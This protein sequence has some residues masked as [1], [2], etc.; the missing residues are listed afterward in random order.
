MAGL[1]QAWPL[2]EEF[3]FPAGEAAIVDELVAH[4]A[5]R[6]SAPEQREV[7]VQPLPADTAGPGLD[8]QQQG[9]PLTAERANAHGR[10]LAKP[11]GK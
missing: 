10:S 4:R 1:A 5:A 9:L 6:P 3:R 8:A 7:P 2:L 11:R